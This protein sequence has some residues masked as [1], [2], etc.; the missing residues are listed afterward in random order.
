MVTIINKNST[1]II[2]STTGSPNL[3]EFLT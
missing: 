1:M 3:I 2:T